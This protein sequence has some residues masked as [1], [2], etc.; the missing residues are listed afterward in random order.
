MD[1][2]TFNKPKLSVKQIENNFKDLLGG[3]GLVK[4]CL[5]SLEP[6]QI[7]LPLKLLST[8]ENFRTFTN[9]SGETIE[10]LKSL[11][12]KNFLVTVLPSLKAF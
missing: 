1:K 12:R 5:S 3:E 10:N 6:Y 8:L 9:E 7:F 11:A 4:F 2:K